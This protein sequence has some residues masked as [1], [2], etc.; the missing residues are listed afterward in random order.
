MVLILPQNLI[1]QN[2]LRTVNRDSGRNPYNGKQIGQQSDILLM[3]KFGRC[4]QYI[5]QRARCLLGLRSEKESSSSNYLQQS[6]TSKNEYQNSRSNKEGDQVFLKR[7]LQKTTENL[8]TES[9]NSQICHGKHVIAEQKNDGTE[10]WQCQQW[11]VACKVHNTVCQM[12]Y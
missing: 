8:S 10:P 2:Y 9:G 4:S 5:V 6:H 7:S 3:I 1:L 12:N 11:F